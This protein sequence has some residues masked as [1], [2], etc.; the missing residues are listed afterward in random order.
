[1]TISEPFSAALRERTAAVHREAERSGFIADLIRGRADRHGYALYLRNLVPVYEAM[2]RA[3]DASGPA[4]P[5]LGAFADPRLRRRDALAADLAALAGPGW[6]DRLVVL[7]E[8]ADHAR[9]VAASSGSTRLVAHAYA[10]YLGDLSGGQILKPVL[11]RFLALPPEALGFYD[12]PALEDLDAA[13]AAMRDA[14]DR[15]APHEREAVAAE[16]VSAFR[17]T[18]AASLAVSRASVGVAA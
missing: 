14:L 11:A 7:P 10:R 5:V 9:D 13:K 17:H 6:A 12:F 15:V 4:D 8:A 16:A 2:E 1:M 18:I 3:L